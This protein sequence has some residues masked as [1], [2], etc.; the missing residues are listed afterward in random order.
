MTHKKVLP[1]A[2]T[3]V[4]FIV[5]PHLHP[6]ENNHR[7]HVMLQSTPDF[8]LLL[9]VYTFKNLPWDDTTGILHSLLLMPLL[10][11]AED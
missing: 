3:G 2:L 11:A 10:L 8:T 9:A 4:R 5:Y 6:W 7:G 1:L